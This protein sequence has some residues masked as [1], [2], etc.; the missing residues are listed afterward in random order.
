MNT[1]LMKCI[2]GEAVLKHVKK[3]F[4][5]K[6]LF[7]HIIEITHN[8]KKKGGGGG[9]INRSIEAFEVYNLFYV[10]YKNYFVLNFMKSFIKW[11]N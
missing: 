1:I 3:R 8:T 6:T 5:D 4:L 9:F 10:K 7:Y 11:E 2:L